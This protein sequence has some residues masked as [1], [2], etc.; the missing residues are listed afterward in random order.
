[1]DDKNTVKLW[2][3]VIISIAIVNIVLGIC[4]L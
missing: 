4:F 1:M 3:L 2:H